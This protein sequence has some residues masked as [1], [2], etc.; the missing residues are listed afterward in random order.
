MAEVRA[1]MTIIGASLSNNPIRPRMNFVIQFGD[2]AE[3]PVAQI[4]AE[5][6]KSGAATE[7]QLREDVRL[8][9]DHNV[10]VRIGND[11]VSGV[12]NGATGQSPS[13]TGGRGRS[14]TSTRSAMP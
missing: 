1:A 9:E 6:G 12:L 10:A 2:Q 8:L 5:A 11:R 7:R 4:A 13:Q 3:I 14:G